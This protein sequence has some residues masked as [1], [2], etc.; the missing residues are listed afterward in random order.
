MKRLS[1]VALPCRV[2]CLFCFAGTTNLNT[3]VVRNLQ[4][5]RFVYDLCLHSIFLRET[6]LV[7]EMTSLALMRATTSY[8]WTD[9]GPFRRHPG[10]CS[11]EIKQQFES[12]DI[13]PCSESVVVSVF[14]RYIIYGDDSEYI[15]YF[16]I[17]GRAKQTAKHDVINPRFSALPFGGQNNQLFSALLR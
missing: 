3:I 2:L 17:P 9:H 1:V 16:C 4:T 6:Y 13:G 7:V 10:S 15:L 12:D 14:P 11:G 5:P 8:T